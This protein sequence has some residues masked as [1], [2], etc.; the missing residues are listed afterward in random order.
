VALT[1][2][3]LIL[4]LWPCLGPACCPAPPP[5]K[6]VVNADQTVI[7][8]WDA[9]AKTQHFIRQAS[10]KS[11]ADDF[12]FIVPTPTQPELAESGNEAFPFLLKLTEPERQ[13]TR[14]PSGGMYCACSAD[15]PAKSEAQPEV[16][17]LAEKLVAGFNAAV[18]QA[19]S[20]DALVDWLKDHGYTFSPEVQAW[21]RPY[22]EAGWRFTALKLAMPPDGKEQKAL[23]TS[24]LR[25]SFKGAESSGRQ[26]LSVLPVH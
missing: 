17:V 26:K 24:A 21:A 3:L 15:P 11:Q 2:A 18:L 10:F 19:E 5:G 4:S 16:T 25:L 7:L 22:V 20:A 14:R 23:A 9:A 6:A 12:G 13:K 1:S 8:I